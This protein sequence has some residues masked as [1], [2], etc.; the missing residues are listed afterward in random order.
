MTRLT[1]KI[2]NVGRARGRSTVTR[3]QWCRGILWRVSAVSLLLTATASP[4]GSL[5][6]ASPPKFGPNGGTTASTEPATTI[7]I[8][9]QANSDATG[10]PSV[11]LDGQS[12]V[13]RGAGTFS[14]RATI[15]RH[16]YVGPLEI[17]AS[18]HQRIRS[19]EIFDRTINGSALGSVLAIV[20]PQSI[21]EATEY[22][23]AIDTNVAQPNGTNC[24]DPCLRV[25]SAGEYPVRIELRTPGGDEVLDA[26]TSYLITTDAPTSSIV[27]NTAAVPDTGSIVPNTGSVPNTASIVPNTASVPDPNQSAQSQPGQT[28]T[29]NAPPTPTTPTPTTPTD[30]SPPLKVALIV[31]IHLSPATDARA[32]QVDP[33]TRNVIALIEALARRPLPKTSV[34]VTP[35]TIDTLERQANN[36]VEAKRSPLLGELQAAISGREVLGETYVRPSPELLDDPRLQSQLKEQIER[37]RTR[38]QQV[39]QVPPSSIGVFADNVPTQGALKTLGVTRVLTSEKAFVGGQNYANRLQP[40]GVDVGSLTGE[41]GGIVPTI[42]MNDRL[43][44]RLTATLSDRKRGDDDVLRG[45]TFLAALALVKRSVSPGN[46]HGVAILVPEETSSSTLDTVLGGIGGDTPLFESATANEL[47][48]L[49]LFLGDATSVPQP[50]QRTLSKAN[51]EV[52]RRFTERNTRLTSYRNLFS[53]PPEDINQLE[54]R[55]LTVWDRSRTNAERLAL[56]T[57]LGTEVD[58]TV[59]DVSL[60]P[61]QTITLTARTQAVPLAIVNNTRKDINAILELQSDNVEFVDGVQD[62]RTGRSLL[63]AIVSGG[64]RILRVNVDVTTRG[65]GSF[66]L[67][68]ILRTPYLA[69]GSPGLALSQTRYGVRSTSIGPVG[70]IIT[71]G[72]LIMLATWWIRT[73]AQRRR[74]ATTASTGPN[75]TDSEKA[76]ASSTGSST[77]A[78]LQ[79]TPNDV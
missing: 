7:A 16:G 65:P 11:R 63:T 29:T 79:M 69:D 10:N 54:S 49:P 1:T 36:A 48:E 74:D 51:D 39:L 12:D 9:S 42:V 15:T 66:S 41:E 14:L 31:P 25:V 72:A 13:V 40:I 59:S 20:P 37:G 35:E 30:A 43:A 52:F 26:F 5:V 58:R 71:I 46:P 68:A 22:S 50:K 57:A 75:P 47:F 28:T 61:S 19:E 24:P 6:F 3:A 34:Y 62:P 8:P 18:I 44:K 64:D 33:N 4:G 27:P 78:L 38:V 53:N 23:V 76:D 60:S 45:Q 56:L 67:L 21:G 17:T 77:P 2:R 55:V 32:R 73:T 70:T